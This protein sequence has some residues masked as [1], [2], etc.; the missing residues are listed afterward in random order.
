MSASYFADLRN[1]EGSPWV[2]PM[3]HSVEKQMVM[4]RTLDHEYLPT[5]G[6]FDFRLAG[7]HL[8]LGKENVAVIQNRASQ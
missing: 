3:V 6:Q 1:D 4:D 5:L 2:L 7:I 8:L